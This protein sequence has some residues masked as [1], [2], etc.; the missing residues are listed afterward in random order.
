MYDV[1]GYKH[2]EHEYVSRTSAQCVLYHE[3]FGL[4][5]YFFDDLE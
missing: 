3:I 1:E 2:L 5:F 4:F